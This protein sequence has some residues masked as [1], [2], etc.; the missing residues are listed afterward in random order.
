MR[1]SCNRPWR[2]TRACSPAKTWS[3]PSGEIVEPV[4]GNVT[5][6]YFY[7]P[8]TWGPREADHLLAGGDEWHNP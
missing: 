5:P 4:L 3:R 6:L 7:K 2:E 1:G 8:G